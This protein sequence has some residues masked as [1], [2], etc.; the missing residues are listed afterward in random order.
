MC[1]TRWV[2]P[3]IPGPQ[4]SPEQLRCPL[5]K[6]PWPLTPGEVRACLSGSA[7][8]RARYEEFTLKRYLERHAPTSFLCPTPGC[9]FAA[10]L[11]AEAASGPGGGTGGGGGARFGCPCCSVD[12]CIVCRLPWHAGERCSGPPDG[13]GGGGPEDHKFLR[14]A[15]RQGL[16][17]CPKCRF[18][19]E[20]SEGCNAVLCRCGTTFCWRCGGDV[21]GD[22]GCACMRDVASLPDAEKDEVGAGQGQVGCAGRWR[23]GGCS[24]C[25]HPPSLRLF[26]PSSLLL[27]PSCLPSTCMDR[28]REAALPL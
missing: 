6:C 19:V 5:P 18:W 14:H 22:A 17:R 2:R 15:G 27:L 26:P 16:R 3:H 7:P 23:G 21:N 24:Q 1:C 8:A 25:G 12:Y 4:V 10:E 9:Q 28:R 13:P 20:K 11:G